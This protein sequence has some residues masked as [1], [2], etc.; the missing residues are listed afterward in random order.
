[1]PTLR[2]ATIL[3][4]VAS[5]IC[6]I[7]LLFLPLAAALFY[8][9]GCFGL[10]GFF[11]CFFEMRG[12]AFGG[13]ALALL[14]FVYLV[15]WRKPLIPFASAILVLVLF[16]PIALAALVKDGFIFSLV[17]LVFIGPAVL[18]LYFTWQHR[19]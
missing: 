12:L 7:G 9:H 10:A 2:T 6:A 18:I 14:A 19:R 17:P 5:L 13:L 4:G 3:F 16:V 15:R 1:M 11:S 8:P